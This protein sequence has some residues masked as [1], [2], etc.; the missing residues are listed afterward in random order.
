VWQAVLLAGLATLAA[1]APQLTNPSFEVDRYSKWPGYARHNGGAITGWEGVSGINPLWRNPEA[2][3]G[4]DAPFLDNGKIPHG[5]QLAFIQG[6]GKLSQRLSG[7]EAGRRYQV[8]YRE[9]ARVHRPSETAEWPRL[10][11]LLGEQVIVSAHKVTPVTRK[12]DF[13]APFYRVE[14]GQFTP[15]R[16]GDYELRFETLQSSSSTVLLDDVRIAELP[17]DTAP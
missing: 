8:T 13:S 10:R 6:P 11:V 17:P 7:L 9:N 12:G 14:S 16:D 1:G 3:Q 4:P 2:Q 15:P 5:K